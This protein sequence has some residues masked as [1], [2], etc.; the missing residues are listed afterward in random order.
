MTTKPT[1][2]SSWLEVALTAAASSG[3]PGTPGDLGGG[4]GDV[5]AA[6]GGEAASRV[7]GGGV[8]GGGEGKGG[9]G[10]GGGNDGWS[11]GGG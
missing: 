2:L 11:F 3:T 6:V 9:G 5:E 7:G 10:G 4:C 8:G 1:Q